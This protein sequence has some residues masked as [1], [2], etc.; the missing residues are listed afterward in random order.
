MSITEILP[1]RIDRKTDLGSWVGQLVVEFPNHDEYDL[2]ALIEERSGKPLHR[3]EFEKIRAYY[4]R[5]RF[6]VLETEE[7][8][9]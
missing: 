2:A 7:E 4:L 1:D 3:D 9:D 6:R 8:D 5:S